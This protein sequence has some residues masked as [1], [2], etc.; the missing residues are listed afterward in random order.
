MNQEKLEDLYIR[1]LDAPLDAKEKEQFLDALHKNAEQAKELAK[2]KKV[3]ELLKA[4][5][6]ATF[7][8]YFVAR[9]VHKIQN[10][11][12]VIDR[13]IFSFFRKF[14]LAAVGVVVALIVLNVVMTD[15]VSIKAILGVESTVPATPAEEIVS[16]DFFE[17]LNNDL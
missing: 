7:G 5:E 14:Q 6:P 4:S 13:Q 11:G 1:S 3:R 12:V 2:H 15:K 16:F 9:L 10:S 17:T 8:P